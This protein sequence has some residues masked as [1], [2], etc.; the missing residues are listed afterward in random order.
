M[1]KS[2]ILLLPPDIFSKILSF[3]EWR[4]KDSDVKNIIILNSAWANKLYKFTRPMHNYIES[5]RNLDN[6]ESTDD[7]A[8]GKFSDEI[9]ANRY[10]SVA[11]SPYLNYILKPR[12]INFGFVRTGLFGGNLVLDKFFYTYSVRN[13]TQ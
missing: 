10:L 11:L 6:R 9:G 5:I 2:N 13:Y 8:V 7:L 3:L 1:S 12:Q 4:S